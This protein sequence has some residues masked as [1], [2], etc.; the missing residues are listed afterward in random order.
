MPGIMGV[1]TTPFWARSGGVDPQGPSGYNPN[2]PENS[3][4][5]TDI[6]N[7]YFSGKGVLEPLPKHTCE[8]DRFGKG[9]V[10]GAYF[11]AQKRV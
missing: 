9:P 8:T 11:R 1:V 10:L 4:P 7:H 6:S 2:W 5:K 3:G